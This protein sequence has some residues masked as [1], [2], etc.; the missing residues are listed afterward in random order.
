MRE[1]I[2]SRMRTGLR[3]PLDRRQRRTI[4]GNLVEAEELDRFL[5]RTFIGQKRF[6]ARGSEAV[7]RPCASSSTARDRAGSIAS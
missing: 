6:S 5:Q 1:W 7:I 3:D 2:I 4:L